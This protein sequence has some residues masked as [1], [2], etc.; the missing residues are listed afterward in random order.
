[1]HFLIINDLKYIFFKR[2]NWIISYLIIVLFFPIFCKINNIIKDDIFFINNG[3]KFDNSSFLFV[4]MYIFNI[5]FYI[6]I[7]Y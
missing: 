1:M 7:A 2:K 4:I 6:I 3:L 5:I